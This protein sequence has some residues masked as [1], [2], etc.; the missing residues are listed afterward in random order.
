[1]GR[2]IV[3]ADAELAGAAVHEKRAGLKDGEA[4]GRIEIREIDKIMEQRT[5]V[6]VV[7]D[8]AVHRGDGVELGLERLVPGQQAREDLA[9]F[10]GQQLAGAGEAE[11]LHDGAGLA[12]EPGLV[13]GEAGVKRGPFLLGEGGVAGAEDR[14][15]YRGLQGREGVGPGGID[16]LHQG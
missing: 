7:A 8:E 14:G 2:G 10:P 9:A 4:V 11:F 6:A 13:G 1:V 16:P 15:D 5:Q 12:A 3:Y